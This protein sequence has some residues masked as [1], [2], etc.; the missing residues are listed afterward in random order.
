VAVMADILVA[1]FAAVQ[2]FTWDTPE[3]YRPMPQELGPVCDRCW[4]SAG[5]VLP[6]S[7]CPHHFNTEADHG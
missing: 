5:K 2:S 6:A 4:M 3:L 1:M 7:V